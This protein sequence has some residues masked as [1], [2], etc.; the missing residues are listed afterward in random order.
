ML[1]HV[2][3]VHFGYK[4]LQINAKFS[5]KLVSPAL[6]PPLELHFELWQII[7]ETFLLCH[8]AFGILLLLLI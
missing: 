3:L 8:L 4:L 2:Q 1:A 7:Y 5:A 6:P